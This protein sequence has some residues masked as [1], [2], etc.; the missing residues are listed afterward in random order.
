MTERN[1]H[2]ILTGLYG[3]LMGAA[4]A[5]TTDHDF[6]RLLATAAT[7]QRYSPIN[8]L[9]LAVQG[10]QGA[11]ANQRMWASMPAVDGHRC[12]I[13]PGEQAMRVLAPIHSTRRVVDPATGR[14]RLDPI[15]NPH[16]RM[17][18]V[19]GEHQLVAPPAWPLD[20]PLR[21]TNQ[22][23]EAAWT[24]VADSLRA[25]GYTVTRVPSEVDPGA[26]GRTDRARRRVA[27]PDDL[28]PAEALRAVI[29]SYATIHLHASVGATEHVAPAVVEVEAETATAIV[30][31]R[32][33]LDQQSDRPPRQ[34]PWEG[35]DLR[36]S[37]S[38]ERVLLVA[39]RITDHLEVALACDLTTDAF[40]KLRRHEPATVAVLRSP[41]VA[42]ASPPAITAEGV[43][44]AGELG[45]AGS[46]DEV[47]G[48]HLSTGVPRWNVLARELTGIDTERFITMGNTPANRAVALAE[49]GA[50]APYVADVLVADGSEMTEVAAALTATM[51][52]AEGDHAPLFD[53]VELAPV[54]RTLGTDPALT[55][56][57]SSTVAIAAPVASSVAIRPTNSPTDLGDELIATWSLVKSGI[58]TKDPTDDLIT[59]WSQVGAAQLPTPAVPIAEPAR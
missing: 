39:D 59:H 5:V 47:I 19:F 7:F 8:R 23:L 13:R 49:A 33:G 4:R 17:V 21:F 36:V 44:F 15:G 16:Y 26:G 20:P 1:D 43:S 52:D 10:A 42:F 41:D 31:R 37:D 12:R 57:T 29:L 46:A 11:V 18:P 40:Q 3:Q 54:L 30:T 48:R 55:P 25:D 38:A 45:V 27:I 56:D 24:A 28:E 58:D 32:V 14:A 35:R 50:T 2:E 34:A 22:D 53:P 9:Y 6:H 51:V